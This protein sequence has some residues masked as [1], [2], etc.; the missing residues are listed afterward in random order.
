MKI[1][2]YVKDKNGMYKLLLDNDDILLIH[3]DLILK[4]E[5]L[6][7]KNIDDSLREKIEKENLIYTAY[8]LSIKYLNTKARSEKEIYEYLKKRQVDDDIIKECISLLRKNNYI[9]DE[10]YSKMYI[11]DKINLSNDGPYKIRKA[12]TDLGVREEY[13]NSNIDIFDSSLEKEKIEKLVDKQ[14]KLN[15]NKSA[16][17]L[18]NKILNYLVNLGYTRSIINEVLNSTNF[19]DDEDLYKKEYDKLYKKLSRKYSGTELDY[20]IKEKMYARGFYKNS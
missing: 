6:L 16:Y 5:L 17:V 20:K 11:N 3:E 19:K 2:K 9:N 1:D 13:I 18:K 4:Y 12:L 7:K 15:H 14:I 10:L 8:N